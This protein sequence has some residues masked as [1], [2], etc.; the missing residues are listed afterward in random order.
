MFDSIEVKTE[1][2]D[3]SVWINPNGNSN[4]TCRITIGKD[5][6]PWMMFADLTK[7]ETR[8]LAFS[9]LKVAELLENE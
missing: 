3:R 2:A 7:S 6:K 5:G 8:I 9:L 1:D 4:E